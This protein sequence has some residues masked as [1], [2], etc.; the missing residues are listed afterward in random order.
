MLCPSPPALT[1]FMA[2]SFRTTFCGVHCQGF[3]FFTTAA[4]EAT[5]TDASNA[6]TKALASASLTSLDMAAGAYGRAAAKE[7]P[8]AAYS[9]PVDLLFDP[10]SADDAH[11]LATWL[12]SERWPFHGR[13]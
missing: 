9:R 10:F 2:V 1:G 7:T 11:E 8:G 5:T 13:Q 12:G 3:G 4:A 6:D